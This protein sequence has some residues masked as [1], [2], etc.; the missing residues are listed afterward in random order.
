MLLM[1]PPKK[2][3]AR[4]SKDRNKHPAWGIRIPIAYRHQLAKL[5]EVNRRTVTEELKIALEKALADH[6]LWP[7]TDD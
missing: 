4:K 6:D 1:A 3:P 7:P 5:A 2:K